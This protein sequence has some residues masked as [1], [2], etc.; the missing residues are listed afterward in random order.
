[1]N[2]DMLDQASENESKERE[3]LI[4][5]ARR[6]KPILAT[7]HCLCCNAELKNGKRWCDEW[8]RDEWQLEQE[9]IKRHGIRL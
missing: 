2:A 8:C 3:R 6:A 9:A 4:E 1:M 5:R 7:G